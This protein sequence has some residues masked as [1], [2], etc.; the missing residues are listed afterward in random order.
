M[1]FMMTDSFSIKQTFIIIIYT[2]TVCIHHIFMFVHVLKI[3]FFKSKYT[4][5]T[6]QI[7]T[8]QTQSSLWSDIFFTA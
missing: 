4:H 7:K 2:D 3:V 1:L 5:K 6:K 8:K